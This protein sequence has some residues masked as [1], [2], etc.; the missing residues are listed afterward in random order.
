LLGEILGAFKLGDRELRGAASFP[1]LRAKLD[2][3]IEHLR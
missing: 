3:A 1:E 2:A